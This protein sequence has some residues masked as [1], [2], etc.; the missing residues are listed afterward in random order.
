MTKYMCSADLQYQMHS[1]NFYFVL[2]KLDNTCQ[3]LGT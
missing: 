3:I 2:I 1:D